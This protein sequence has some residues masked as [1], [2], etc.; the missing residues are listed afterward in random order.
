MSPK[1]IMKQCLLKLSV[2]GLGIHALFWS[3]HVDAA[4]VT[5]F[6]GS[7]DRTTVTYWNTGALPDTNDNVVIG[8]GP[9]IALP[10]F[11]GTLA[12]NSV[13]SQQALVLSGGSEPCSF[14]AC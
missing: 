5:W 13:Q 3:V 6:G 10:Y 9:S 2:A 8:A 1:V 12:S 14:T 11:S 4:T 7:G